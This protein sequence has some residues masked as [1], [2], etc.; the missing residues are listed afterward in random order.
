MNKLN[1]FMIV[2]MF[3]L[4]LCVHL[5]VL[6]WLEVHVEGKVC[7]FF[8]LLL[9]EASSRL[10]PKQYHFVWKNISIHV[11]CYELEKRKYA[12]DFNKSSPPKSCGFDEYGDDKLCCSDLNGKPFK[13]TLQ[14]PK[15]PINN[16][17]LYACNDHTS[18]CSKW[19]KDHP[20]SCSP[21]HDS[22]GFM[23]SA[24]QKSCGRCGSNVSWIVHLLILISSWSLL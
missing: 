23:R 5:I 11:H 19:A 4:K 12:L 18:S 6:V 7:I 16:P 21:G 2:I 24:C 17:K 13:T 9:L 22:Y 14:P 3:F 10:S 15:Y 1:M 8:N 20:E